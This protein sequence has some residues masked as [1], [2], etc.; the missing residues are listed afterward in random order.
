[1]P[2]ALRLDT[3]PPMHPHPF[4]T[5]EWRHLAMLNFVVQ[6]EWLQPMVPQ[7]TVVDTYQ[8][9]AYLSLVGFLFVSTKVMGIPVFFHQQFEEVNL[10]FYVR[11]ICGGELRRGVVFIKEIVPALLISRFARF[12][13]NENY[14]TCPMRHRIERD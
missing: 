5:A 11:R 6:P 14:I 12:L 3:A 7:G 2:S 4:L 13:Y 10:R 9:Q 1:M 8:G